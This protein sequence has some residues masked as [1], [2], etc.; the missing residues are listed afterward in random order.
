MHNSRSL[1]IT[2]LLAGAGAGLW[3]GIAHSNSTPKPGTNVSQP[4]QSIAQVPTPKR[5]KIEVNTTSGAA[6]LA[7]A[8][9]LRQVGAKM[10]GA[11]WCPHCQDQIAL[12]GRQA[13]PSV[14]YV[15]CAEDGQ[16]SQTNLCTREKIKGFPTWKIKGKTYEGTQ[17]L[18]DLAKASGYRG[19]LSFK[20]MVP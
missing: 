18:V 5:G 20:N 14:P 9:H 12:F 19:P 4:L 1:L 6:E 2:L 11:Y 3:A 13:A 7:L 15:E 17:S 10:Y 8:K 16:N